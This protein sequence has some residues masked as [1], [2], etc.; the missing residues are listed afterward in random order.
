MQICKPNEDGFWESLEGDVEARDKYS[1][2]IYKEYP[3]PLE[4]SQDLR[5]TFAGF[6]SNEDIDLVPP[7]V[8]AAF[9]LYRENYPDKEEWEEAVR[10]AICENFG[11]SGFNWSDTV[12]RYDKQTGLTRLKGEHVNLPLV[13]RILAT[14]LA[15]YDVQEVYTISASRLHIEPE[16]DADDTFG[17]EVCA[18]GPNRVA[19]MSTDDI[20]PQLAERVRNDLAPQFSP[21]MGM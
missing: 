3:F 17:G 11:D 15:H 10:E 16:W 1:Y 12:C 14:I 7:Y 18:V 4:V 13:G 20:A 8:L 2:R 21:R 5:K 6:R 9:G 19:I